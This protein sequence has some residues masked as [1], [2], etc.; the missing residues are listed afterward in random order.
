LVD[1]NIHEETKV[2]DAGKMVAMRSY[3]GGMGVLSVKAVIQF[4]LF[5]SL[6]YT[7]VV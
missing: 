4:V 7:N 1:I 5:T 3:F 2:D 6:L